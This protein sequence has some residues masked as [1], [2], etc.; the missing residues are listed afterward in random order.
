M[1]LEKNHKEFI[2]SAVRVYELA[3]TMDRLPLGD[4]RRPCSPPV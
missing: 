3:W 4:G 2:V 1:Y